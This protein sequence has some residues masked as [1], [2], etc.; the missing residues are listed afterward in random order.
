VAEPSPGD[1]VGTDEYPNRYTLREPVKRGGEGTIWRATSLRPD[2]RETWTSAIKIVDARSLQ[3]PFDKTPGEVLEEYC[4]RASRARLEAAH[5]SQ[6]VPQ[7]VA[8]TEVFLG[9]EP[10]QVSDEPSG[11]CAYVVSPWVE[12]DDLGTWSRHRAR[13]F[14]ETCDVLEKLAA[15]LDAMAKANAVHRDI[16][17]GNV[18]LLPDG[19]VRLIDLT[20]LRPSKTAYNTVRVGTHGFQAPEAARGD[21]DFP[22]DRYSFG[23]LAFYL[24]AGR[25]AATQDA[26][27]DSRAWLVRAGLGAAIAGHVAALLDADPARRPEVLTAWVVELRTLGRPEE[28]SPR[29]RALAMAVDGTQVPRVTAAAAAGVFGARLGPRLGWR[30]AQDTD[31][32]A[33]VIDLALVIDGVGEPVTFAATGDGQLHLGRSGEWTSTGPAVV[34]TGLAAVRDPYGTAVAY[35]IAR[36]EHELVMITAAP[37]GRW[38]RSGTSQPAHRVLGAATSLDGSPLVLVLSPGNEL[39]CSDAAGTSLVCRDGAFAAAACTGRRGELYCYR[40]AA[41]Q[42]SLEWYERAPDGWDLVER[43]TTPTPAS[44]IACA[45]HREGT[46]VTVAGPDGVYVAA[47]AEGGFA[48]WQQVTARPTSH[49][50]LA[51]GARWR[52]QLGALADGQVA[53]AEED[54]L[55]N[56]QH[57]TP[58]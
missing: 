15:A 5:L 41:E 18:M 37:G 19:Q 21:F 3:V 55:G 45:S 32:P 44:A 33:D 24:L 2:G 12:G 53:L 38:R 7:V 42:R 16:S 14:A 10:H 56:W 46:S 52:L 48:P 27:A 1:R 35:A 39:L 28:T 9:T 30:L 49:V 26:A 40:A 8:P 51:V 6:T 47:H 54:F 58:F 23:A 4:D 29:F 43:V 57:R 36:E 22:A 34:G 25:E 31:G 50:A 11:R 20:Y 13:A 17:P